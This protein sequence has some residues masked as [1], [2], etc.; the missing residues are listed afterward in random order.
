MGA[1]QAKLN[2]K[3]LEDLSEKTKFSAKEIK[4]WHNGFMKDCPTGKLSKGEFSKIYTQFFPKGDPTAFSQFVFNVF[5]DNGDGSIEFEE[6]L[7]ALSVTSRGKLD[8][9]LE[10]AFRLY[11]LDNDGTITRKEM[12]AI[13][14]AI[15]SMVGEN[16]KKESCTPQ[17]RV[18]KIFDKMDKDGNGSLSKEEFMEVAKTDKSIVQGRACKQVNPCAGFNHFVGDFFLS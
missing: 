12:T 11:D 16:E 15:F 9:K 10:W 4:H 18:N 13:V 5:D 3:Q 2:K 8:E 17:E 6:F 7:Q 1:K 14:E